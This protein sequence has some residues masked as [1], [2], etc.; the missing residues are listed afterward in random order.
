MPGELQDADDQIAEG[1]HDV[2]A[3]AGLGG[4]GVLAEGDV[5]DRL[6]GEKVV[7]RRKSRRRR[8]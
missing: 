5:T 3:G 8:R 4:G 2:R 1:G 6:I 7:S